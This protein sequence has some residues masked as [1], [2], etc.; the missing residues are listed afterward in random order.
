MSDVIFCKT[1]HVTNKELGTTLLWKLKVLQLKEGN[2]E[3]EMDVKAKEDL[4]DEET[5]NK[6]ELEDS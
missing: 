5:I 4:T 2:L 3:L 1:N 6:A